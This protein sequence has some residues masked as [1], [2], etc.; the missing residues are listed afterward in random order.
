VGNV[1][2][3]RVAAE[4]LKMDRRHLSRLLHRGDLP[5]AAW[6]E[7][8]RWV[9]VDAVRAALEARRNGGRG[10]DGGRGV[11]RQP[12]QRKAL[13]VGGDVT[14][15]DGID[16]AFRAMATAI[17][18][19][20]VAASLAQL[21][22]AGERQYAEAVTLVRKTADRLAGSMRNAAGWPPNRNAWPRPPAATSRQTR[23]RSAPRRVDGG[24]GERRPGGR[25]P[26]TV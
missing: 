20:V 24:A 19:D 26:L 17:A 11:D 22:E 6:R 2:P 16:A 3:V 7:Q 15:S 10:R 23:L 21:R 4:R 18:N 5:T 12:D 14:D 8:G 1:V 25:R 9:D 13:Y